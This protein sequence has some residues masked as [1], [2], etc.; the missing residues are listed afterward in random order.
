M[1][2]PSNSNEFR[3]YLLDRLPPERADAIEARMFQDDAFFSDLQDAED[4]LIEE[5]VMEEMGS[6]EAR[7]FETRVERDPILQERVVIR[8]ALIRTLRSPSAE[9]ATVATATR[10]SRRM[11]GRF[12]VPGFAF[13]IVLLFFISYQAEHRRGVPS[14]SA[15]TAGAPASVAHQQQT[16]SQAAA[17]L[18]LPA[19]AVRG[20]AQRPSVLHIGSAAVVRLELET[21]SADAW[22]RWNVGI[23]DGGASVFSAEGLKSQQAG[24]VSYVIAEVRAAQLPPKVYQITLTPESS[25]SGAPAST[26][27]LQVVQ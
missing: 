20:A 5:Y 15:A 3:D 8:R 10:A 18:F 21:A 22:A 1:N 2:P 14:R 12:L 7:V 17:V 11:W 24:V 16:M 23:S 27:D 13:A 6:A 4:E 19:H 9:P 25:S 26:W